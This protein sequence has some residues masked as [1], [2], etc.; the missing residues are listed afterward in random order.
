VGSQKWTS[1]LIT[2]I[3]AV[4]VSYVVFIVILNVELPPGFLGRI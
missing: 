4:I 3:F 2:S 1:V